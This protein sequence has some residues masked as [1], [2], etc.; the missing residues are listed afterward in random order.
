MAALKNEEKNLKAAVHEDDQAI[1][2]SH[3]FK[4]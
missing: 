3:G 4:S 1:V 2:L